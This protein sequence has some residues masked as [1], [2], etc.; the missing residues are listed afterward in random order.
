[1]IIDKGLDELVDGFGIASILEDKKSKKG[2]FILNLIWIIVKIQTE[3]LHLKFKS[4]TNSS[5]YNDGTDKI[6]ARYFDRREKQK[7]WRSRKYK[8]EASSPSCRMRGNCGKSK[9]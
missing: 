1:M 9:L 2:V 8:H 3:L 6:S 5:Q 4:N 7:N